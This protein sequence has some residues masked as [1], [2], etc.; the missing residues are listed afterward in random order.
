[1]RKLILVLA[2]LPG[3]AA[4]QGT[5]TPPRAFVRSSCAVSGRCAINRQVAT[6]IPA[7]T[8][9]AD[10]PTCNTGNQLG[11][12]ESIRH[13]GRSVYEGGPLRR[14]PDLKLCLINIAIDLAVG[15]ALAGVPE[16]E[17][18]SQ[19]QMC[20]GP[21]RCSVLD[22]ATDSSDESRFLTPRRCL[23]SS[24]KVHHVIHM[25]LM[26]MLAGVGAQ[27]LVGGDGHYNFIAF[28]TLGGLGVG[29]LS[30]ATKPTCPTEGVVRG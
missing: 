20:S 28:N 22:D 1:M 13:N 18:P 29:A 7:P 9:G 27:M 25:G 14:E 24:R 4:A 19:M 2:F 3:V 11:T 5:F 23:T 17:P 21:Q 10:L 26:G 12:I 8:V 15:R 6:G 30:A 16:I